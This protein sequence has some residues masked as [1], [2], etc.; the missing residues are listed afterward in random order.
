MP[1]LRERGSRQ[2]GDVT[3]QE[4]RDECKTPNVDERS[5]FTKTKTDAPLNQRLARAAAD[6]EA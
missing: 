6:K 1:S 5:V 4:E 2:I 3:A